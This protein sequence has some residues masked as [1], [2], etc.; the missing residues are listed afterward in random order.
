MWGFSQTPGCQT[1]R[2]IGFLWIAGLHVETQ[3]IGS[4]VVPIT[5]I[6]PDATS[7]YQAF[8]DEL[9]DALPRVSPIE[10]PV[11]HFNA[12]VGTD[13][14]TWKCVIGKHEVT[15]LNENGKYLLQLSRSNGLRIMNTFFQHRKVQKY[16]WYRPSMD[17]K[18]FKGFCIVSL[19]LFFDVLDVR[20]KR[21]AELSTDH[22]PVVWS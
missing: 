5:D 6:C 11:F 12:R 9:N 14:D 15:G 8:V 10:S 3:G 13:T 7:E 16:T 4:V 19:D 17:Q 22:H 18:S 1:A 2:Q 20:V 21:G